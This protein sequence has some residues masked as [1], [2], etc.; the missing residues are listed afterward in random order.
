M[1]GVFSRAG[2]GGRGF[3]PHKLRHTFATQLLN[4]GLRIDII[5]R[6]LGHAGIGTTQMYAH[7]EFGADLREKLDA[8]L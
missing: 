7:T 4:K 5:Q 1:K 3:T 8:Y 6:L 2:L